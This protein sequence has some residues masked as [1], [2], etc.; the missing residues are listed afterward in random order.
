MNL[1]V[2]VKVFL[3]NKD[4]KILL[5]KRSFEKYGKTEG[6]WDIVGGRIDPGT[7]LMENL[8]R[9]VSEETQLTIT[10]APKLIGAQDIIPNDERHIVRLT[11]VAQTDGEPV[12]DLSE[13]TEY[14]WVTFQEL[15]EES[16]LDAYAKA[17]VQTNLLSVDSWD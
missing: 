13:N 15:S 1:Q 10:S 12:L 6:A 2:G 4:D 5:V 8:R 9:E 14:K 17:L 11:Y 3:R 7:P 16:E